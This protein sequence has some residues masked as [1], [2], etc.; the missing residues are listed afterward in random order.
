MLGSSDS[1]A[2]TNYILNTIAAD[3]LMEFADK[4][5]NAKDFNKELQLLVRET[6]NTHKRIIFNGDGYTEDWAQEAERRGLLNLRTTVDALPYYIKPENIALF[7]RHGIFG[8]PEMHSRYE[9]LMEN[10]CKV[11]NIEGLTMLDMVKKDIFPSVSA[12]MGDLSNN[13]LAKESSVR[14]FP[15]RAKSRLSKTFQA[16]LL[17]HEIRRGVGKRADGRCRMQ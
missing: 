1:I 17:P 13:A 7:E 15:A 4:L 5:E 10:Y 6:L 9:I 3:A 12:Y 8:A 11:L 16:V 2:C 14:A